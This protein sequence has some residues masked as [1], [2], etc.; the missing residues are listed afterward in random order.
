MPSVTHLRGTAAAAAL[1]ALPLALVTVPAHTVSGAPATAA[2]AYTARLAI[3]DGE[4]ACSGALVNPRWVLTAAS[5]F[6]DNPASGATPVAGAPA[7][8]T[9]ATL[10][11][12]DLTTSAGLVTR[13]V[14]LVPYQ[15]RDLVLAR[16]EQP[17][18]GVAGISP[19]PLAT[20]AP[21]AGETLKATGY[22]R[23][24]TEWSPLAVH[25]G[26]FTVDSAGDGQAAITGQDGAAVCA[27]DTGGPLVREKDGKAELVGINSRSWQGGCFGQEPAETRTGAL[28][29]LVDD[30]AIQDWAKE[31][32]ERL[33]EV[34]NM[35]DVS[36]DGADDLVILGADGNI[37]VRTAV[38][39]FA[40]QPGKP[41][42]RFTPAAH[43]SAG[44]GNFLGRPGEGRLYFA[45]VNG[46]ARADLVVHGTDG[47]VSVRM[48]KGSYFDGGAEWSAGWGNFLGRPG[49]GRLY[50]AD[51]NGDA[52]ADLV[53]HGTDGKVS[54]R[55]NK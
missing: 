51:V 37:T 25:A 1:V 31:A 54:V 33:R 9:V 17:T 55:M 24:R 30:A 5:C 28:S 45:D 11:R 26:S 49:E 10:G 15:G 29:S 42:Y 14:E 21:T 3:G 53:V 46:D 18:T 16:L 7:R 52:R 41:A 23:T 20:T 40:P 35:A 48:N 43:W 47:K 12:S 32:R 38:K 44:W 27:G 34:V 8:K 39:N 6:V 4:R 2:S 50:F 22:G 36:G 13:V 19:I